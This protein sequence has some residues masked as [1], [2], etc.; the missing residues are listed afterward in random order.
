MLSHPVPH[1]PQMLR[2]AYRRRTIKIS[3]EWTEEVLLTQ[4]QAARF[5]SQSAI[6]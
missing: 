6:V 1:N 3:V 5:S 4:S 2:D